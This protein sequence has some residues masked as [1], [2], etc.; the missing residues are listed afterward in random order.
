[1]VGG[2]VPTGE[3]FDSII[4]GYYEGANLQYAARVRNGFVPPSR[5]AL[6]KR[7]RR[8]QRERYP[9]SNLPETHKGKWGEG[10]TV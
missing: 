10:L 3:S 1:V 5:Q 4:V 2:Y 8:L 7:L 6:L 9:F